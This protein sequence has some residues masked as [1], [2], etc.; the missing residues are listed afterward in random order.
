MR[1]TASLLASG[2]LFAGCATNKPDMKSDD[3]TAKANAASEHMVV[4][5]SLLGLCFM[6]LLGYPAIVRILLS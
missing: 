6:A 5:V 3:A 2:L 1:I 4:P